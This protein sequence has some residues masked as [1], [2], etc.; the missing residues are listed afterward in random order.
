MSRRDDEHVSEHHG[1]RYI[2]LKSG[3]LLDYWS[4]HTDAERGFHALARGVS[5]AF[6]LADDDYDLERL[7]WLI[8]NVQMYCDSAMAEI[9]KQ[10][11]VKTQEERIALLRNVTGREPGEAEA[12]LRKADELERRMASGT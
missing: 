10:R 7:G 6:K 5:R 11:G 1:F 3:R 8:E 12:F 9:D 2:K 4:A